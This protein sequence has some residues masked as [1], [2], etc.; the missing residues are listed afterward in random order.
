MTK[1]RIQKSTQLYMAQEGYK[2]EAWK[3]SV[4]IFTQKDF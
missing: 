3:Q 1:V 2:Q 4:K